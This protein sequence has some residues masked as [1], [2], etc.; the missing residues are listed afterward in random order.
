MTESQKL[1][2]DYTRNRAEAAFRALVTRYVDLVFSTALR[3]VDGDVHRAQDVAQ[4]V[5]MDLARQ[6]PKLATHTMLG[7]CPR[8]PGCAATVL[9]CGRRGG[10]TG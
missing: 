3:L 6:A 7:G 1:L 5:F 2:Q 4:T 10:D 8:P 9:L